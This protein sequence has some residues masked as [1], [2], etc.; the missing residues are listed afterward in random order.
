M[1]DRSEAR[2]ISDHAGDLRAFWNRVSQS[3]RQWRAQYR[4][5][6]NANAEESLESRT[7]LELQIQNDLSNRGCLSK[8]T[9]DAVMRWGFGAES[10]CSDREVQQATRLAFGHLSEG[11]I[12]E[13]AKTLVKLP[14]IGISR[15]SKVLALS[16]QFQ[17]GIYDS[18]S[19]HGLSDLVDRSDH[20][21]IVI[22]PG[23]VIRGDVRTKDEYCRAFERY[24][25]T[26][27]YFRDLAR[28]DPSLG[29]SFSRLA[30]LEIA[31]FA[32]SRSG[33]V[34]STS[35]PV[36]PDHLRELAERN[37]EDA[38]WTLG[39]GKKSTRFFAVISS[40]DVTVF[41]GA[42]GTPLALRAGEVEA[43]L[44]HFSPNWFPLSNSKTAEDRCPNGLGEYF[45]KRFGSSVF[46]S[47][48][49]AL[50]VHQGRLDATRRRGAWHLRVIPS[51]R[52]NN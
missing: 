32:R 30:D 31:F 27:R 3:A 1:E 45:A 42:K 7:R 24:T 21:I 41:T 17:F 38:Y 10:G 14:R 28:K 39:P 37:E 15:A 13:A 46:A 11:R 33:L 20:G 47:H 19:A 16:D 18:R 25:W 9:F 12:A 44:S 22:P 5:P 50:W 40:E 23:R 49:A 29:V 6:R 48:F 52:Q 36:V 34:E 43:C 2:F 4:W 26:L 8:A 51:D 35:R